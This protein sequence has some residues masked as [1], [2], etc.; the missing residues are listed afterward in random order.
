MLLIIMG[1]VV[2][3]MRFSGRN[4]TVFLES[5]NAKTH[6]SMRKSVLRRGQKQVPKIFLGVFRYSR[7]MVELCAYEAGL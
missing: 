7:I 5:M 3:D 1:K 6:F 4:E 2:A